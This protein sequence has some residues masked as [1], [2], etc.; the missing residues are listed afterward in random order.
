VKVTISK[1]RDECVA[2]V[3][4]HFD[5]LEF[6]VDSEISNESKKNSLHSS[7][8]L[9]TLNT[10]LSKEINTLLLYSKDLNSNKFLETIPQVEHEV[11]PNSN[12]FHQRVSKELKENEVYSANVVYR[13]EFLADVAFALKRLVNL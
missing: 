13:D 10:L 2:L 12:E 3:H 11:F 7:Y 9:E 1:A 8:R 6:N 5:E 4:K